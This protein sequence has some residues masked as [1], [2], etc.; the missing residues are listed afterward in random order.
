[1]WWS[2][3]QFTDFGIEENETDDKFAK[4]STKKTG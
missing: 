4:V 3:G 1:M 2:P